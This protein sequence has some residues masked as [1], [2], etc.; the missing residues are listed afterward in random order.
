LFETGVSAVESRFILVVDGRACIGLSRTEKLEKE[1]PATKTSEQGC[2]TF[3][4][5]LFTI[6]SFRKVAVWILILT[7]TLVFSKIVE[8]Y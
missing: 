5:L 8:V 3:I 2:N 4:M 1:L 7:G 6:S